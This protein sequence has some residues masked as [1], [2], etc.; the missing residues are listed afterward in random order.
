[1]ENGRIV[2]GEEIDGEWKNSLWRRVAGKTI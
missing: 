2:C 1:M